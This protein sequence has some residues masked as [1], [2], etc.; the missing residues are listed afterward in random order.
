MYW[1]P[2]SK[3]IGSEPGFQINLDAGIHHMAVQ[4]EYSA[5]QS[6]MGST[7]KW[8]FTNEDYLQKSQGLCKFSMSNLFPQQWQWLY[9]IP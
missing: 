8:N 3:N 6:A 4:V 2:V 7:S 5:I 9:I 1:A